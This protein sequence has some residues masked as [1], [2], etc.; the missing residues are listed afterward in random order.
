LEIDPVTIPADFRLPAQT[1]WPIT[2]SPLQGVYLNLPFA[3]QRAISGIVYVD[4]DGDSQFDPQKDVVVEG[5]RVAAG[6]SEAVST[7]QGFY[8]LRNLPAGR[9]E[10]HIYQSTGKES[11]IINIELGPDPILRNGVNLVA[12][13]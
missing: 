3:A 5:A 7:R 13:E 12:S 8:L 2:V 11:G 6:N 9:I 4:K 1:A 10:V